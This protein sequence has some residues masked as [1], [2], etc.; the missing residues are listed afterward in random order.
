VRT[1]SISI[2]GIILAPILRDIQQENNLHLTT[3]RNLLLR[4]IADIYEED[5]W[6]D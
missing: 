3:V 6:L 2:D 4:Q 5:Q 1:S